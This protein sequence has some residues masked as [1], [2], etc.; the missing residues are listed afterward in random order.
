MQRKGLGFGAVLLIIVLTAAFSITCTSA[1]FIFDQNAKLAD[2]Y[3]D[4]KIYSKLNELQN[5]VDKHY[6]GE[7]DE[8]KLIDGIIMGYLYGIGDKYAAYFNEE[9]YAA[10]KTESMGQS[11]GIGILVSGLVDENGLRIIRV[12][13]GSPAANAG[14]KFGDVITSINGKSVVEMGYEQSLSEMRGEL[15]TF[16]VFDVV[17]KTAS[18]ESET[19]SFNIERDYYDIQYIRSDVVDGIAY[20]EISSFDGTSSNEFI[21]VMDGLLSQNIKGLVFDLRNNSGGSLVNI[22]AILDKLLPEGP[23]V[24][25]VESNGQTRVYKS[26]ATCVDLPMAVVVN[27]GT[28]SA[29]ELFTSALRDYEMATIIG[30][31]TFGKGTVIDLYEFSDKKTAVYIST[32]LYNPPFSENFEGIGITPDI[33]IDLTEEQYLNFYDLDYNTDPQLK[34]AFDNVKEKI[35]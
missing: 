22:L 17:R 35:K 12:Y 6:I 32:T 33:E 11:V 5:L 20:V 13:D 8:Q 16:A 1:Y 30:T 26:G 9:E 4:Q 24:N 23:I 21:S 28:A 34:A 31:T 2:S 14:V 10:F 25:I 19:V 27:G 3:A 29:A 18:G 7:V 15:D